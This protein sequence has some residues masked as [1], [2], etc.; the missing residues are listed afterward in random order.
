MALPVAL[1]EAEQD[2]RDLLTRY[3]YAWD[4]RD[5]GGCVG[6]FAED[7]V[8]IT[9]RGTYEGRD[10][11]R[12]NYEGMANG[13]GRGQGEGSVHRPV[14]V[15]VRGESGTGK[16]LV[17]RAIHARGPRR[18]QPFIAVNCTSI[19]ES[20]VE[21]ELFGHEAGAYTDAREAKRGLFELAHK[22]TIF[23][24]EIGDMPKTM[25]AKLLQVLETH[26]FRRVG[27]TRTI[28]V[29]VHVVTAT[30]RNLEEAVAAGEFREDLFYR[31]NVVPVHLPALRERPEDIMPL[32][33]HF[34]DVHS[35]AHN[36]ALNF[37]R[38]R[39]ARVAWL[40]ALVR[41]GKARVV[42]GWVIL[43]KIPR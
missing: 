33:L 10:A 43:R 41:V 12:D 23:L 31:L 11:I 5:I 14:N 13:R 17:A 6:L 29:D 32:A 25:Q 26:E 34:R 1:L 40:F 7:A 35:H 2:V 3:A 20:L 8:L 9:T 4:S 36:H 37:D 16:D 39:P 24:D 19:P 38:N 18:G 15:L 42:D 27:G 30:N 21:S 22:G 28:E